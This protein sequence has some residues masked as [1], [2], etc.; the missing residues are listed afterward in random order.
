MHIVKKVK[1][2]EF[3]HKKLY[4]VFC[5]GSLSIENKTMC[6]GALVK[7][8]LNENIMLYAEKINLNKIKQ[9]VNHN[10]FEILAATEI[11]KQC[12]NQRIEMVKLFTDSTEVVD[13]FNLYEKQKRSKKISLTSCEETKNF[14]ETIKK[15][16]YVCINHIKRDF[17]MDADFLTRNNINYINNSNVFFKEEAECLDVNTLF[18]Q[19]APD[20][21]ESTDVFENTMK[22]KQRKK[23]VNREKNKLILNSKSSL[24]SNIK[25]NSVPA[26]SLEGKLHKIVIKPYVKN[27]KNNRFYT[28]SY[29]KDGLVIHVDEFTKTQMTINLYKKKSVDNLDDV[30]KKIIVKYSPNNCNSALFFMVMNLISESSHLNFVQEKEGEDSLVVNFNDDFWKTFTIKHKEGFSYL[31]KFL[32]IDYEQSLILANMEKSLFHMNPKIFSI[33]KEQYINNFFSYYCEQAKMDDFQ[34]VE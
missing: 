28:P 2:Y 16:K 32:I 10:K 19:L 12:L 34:I 23:E 21:G 24:L 27:V 8:D 9:V 14:I 33:I 7:N 11:I 30:Y 20:N 13:C 3:N 18:S 31:R 4:F 22:E 26:I 17:N 29:K 1:D 6:F 15:L 5:D 25:K